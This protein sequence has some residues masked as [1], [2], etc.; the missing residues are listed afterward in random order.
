MTETGRFGTLLALP[1]PDSAL[2]R[3]SKSPWEFPKRR[4]IVAGNLPHKKRNE[5]D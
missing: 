1:T 5:F 4:G 3:M 2:V